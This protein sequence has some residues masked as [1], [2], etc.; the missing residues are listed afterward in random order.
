MNRRV[1]LGPWATS[2]HATTV[3]I[4]G[5]FWGI[6]VEG[7]AAHFQS[8]KNKEPHFPEFLSTEMS[9]IKTR[10]ILPEGNIGFPFYNQKVEFTFFNYSQ[11][12][13]EF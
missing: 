3:V 2:A 7:R 9:N 13:Q 10:E 8:L 11:F 6:R 12:F 1:L 5:I 4:G